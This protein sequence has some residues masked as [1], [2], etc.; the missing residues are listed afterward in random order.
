MIAE[1]QCVL[2]ISNIIGVKPSVEAVNQPSSIVEFRYK[3]VVVSDLATISS[4]LLASPLLSVAQKSGY[5]SIRDSSH[6]SKHYR[7][8]IATPKIAYLRASVVL[9]D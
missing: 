8:T 2:N 5:K 7:Q 4:M 9:N 1:N 3:T 6:N